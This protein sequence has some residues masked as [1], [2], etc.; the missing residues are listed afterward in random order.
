MLPD[1]LVGR[2]DGPADTGREREQARRKKKNKKENEKGKRREKPRLGRE[3]DLGQTPNR[4][5]SLSAPTRIRRP[6]D[7]E[8]LLVDLGPQIQYGGPNPE[9]GAGFETLARRPSPP[10]SESPDQRTRAFVCPTGLPA[11]DARLG[12][13]F[14]RGRLSEISGPPSSGRT[15]LALMLVQRALEQGGLVGW[16]DLSDA[17]DPVSAAHGEMALERLLWVRP[18]CEKEALHSCDRLL[19]TEGFELVVFDCVSMPQNPMAHSIP[20]ARVR[21][22]AHTR[23]PASRTPPAHPRHDSPRTPSIS[24]VAWLRLS[25]RAAQTRTAL[26]VLSQTR[27]SG[28]ACVPRASITGSRSVLLL[29]M[30]PLG[31]H[32]TGAPSLLDSLESTA[33]LRRHR[34][35]PS[36]AEIS[37]CAFFDAPCDS[38]T[39]A[40]PRP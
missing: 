16:I 14:P 4:P 37:L 15:A 8:A 21:S 38:E 6:G 36:G 20:T 23:H 11:L 26:V 18:R 1:A 40:E 5:A 31:A 28:P 27:P 7:L 2:A 30:L 12:G 24:D 35:R 9:S 29:E 3:L 32:F 34:T 10:G 17:F 25:R 39:S 19:Q 22:S 33:I 13:G